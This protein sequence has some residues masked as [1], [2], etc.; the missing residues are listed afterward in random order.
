[1]LDNCT[2]A[3]FHSVAWTEREKNIY[4][5][6]SLVSEEQYGLVGLQSQ[7]FGLEKVDGG[8]VDLDHASSLLNEGH[9]G[10]GF[11]YIELSTK[12]HDIF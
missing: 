1:M 3:T 12:Q 8:T 5:R 7:Y 9:G 6:E 10:G 4:L 11:L 2:L